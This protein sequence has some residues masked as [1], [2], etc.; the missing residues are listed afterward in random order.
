M[1]EDRQ[2]EFLAVASRHWPTLHELGFV[3]DLAP[4]FYGGFEERGVEGPFMME[5]FEWV[6]PLGG[7]GT[8]V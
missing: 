7:N 6:D 3:T 4:R 8:S 1:K 5:V 2:D